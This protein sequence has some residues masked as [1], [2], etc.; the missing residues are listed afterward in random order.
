[1]P[2]KTLKARCR[3]QLEVVKP[4]PAGLAAPA[5]LFILCGTSASSRPQCPVGTS[6]GPAARHADDAL[7]APLTR[8]RHVRARSAPSTLSSG[9]GGQGG[10]SA[11]ASL[12][13]V[14]PLSATVSVPVILM[15]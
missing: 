15:S 13:F 11:V 5:A 6:R 9:G 10:G 4:A 2:R 7:R 3:P 1:T 8:F 14:M 12:L